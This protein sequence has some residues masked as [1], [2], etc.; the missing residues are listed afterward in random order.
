MYPGVRVPRSVGMDVG[1][2]FNKVARAGRTAI[3]RTW[4]ALHRIS[5]F[6]AAVM[7]FLA[8]VSERMARGFEQATRRLERFSRLSRAKELGV[9]LGVDLAGDDWDEPELLPEAATPPPIPPAA[10]FQSGTTPSDEDWAALIAAAKI[11]NTPAPAPAV[12]PTDE[13]EA[14]VR[15]AKSSATPAPVPSPA[16]QPSPGA[17][18]AKQPSLASVTPTVRS[19]GVGSLAKPAPA[20][21]AHEPSVDPHVAA[22]TRKTV[23]SALR[24]P[25]A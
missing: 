3:K 21:R 19:P 5:A 10:F 2:A 24:M 12:P 18:P 17:P 14:A 11:G 9:P 8:K 1:R 22:A 23:A 13:W 20:P 16:K 6:L 4:R 25:S 7:R 15:A